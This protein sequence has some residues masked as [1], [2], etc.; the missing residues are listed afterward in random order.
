MDI[1]RRLST[2]ILVKSIAI[3]ACAEGYTP[4]NEPRADTVLVGLIIYTFAFAIYTVATGAKFEVENV[5]VAIVDEDR[6]ML[7]AWLHD[8]LPQPFFKSPEL[9]DADEI[10]AVMEAGRFVFVV[11]IPP[12]L[13]QDVIA[14][15]H[16]SVQ[17][18]IDATA[19]SQ[20]GVS[21][22]PA[23]GSGDRPI[24]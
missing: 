9:I 2:L 5:A 21:R 19:M 12:K 10:N 14:G 6:S 7:S 20:A 22:L 1:K 11:E 18:D 24:E 13:E 3:F 23:A 16:P 8:G 17:I 4:T 15:H